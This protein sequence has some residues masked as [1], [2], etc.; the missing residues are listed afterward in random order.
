MLA[1]H[2]TVF[3]TVLYKDYLYLPWMHLQAFK[4]F[5][6]STSGLEQEKKI[7]L[8]LNLMK[9]WLHW[10]KHKICIELAVSFS[11]LAS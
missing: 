10:V 11:H 5:L 2:T 4:L 7:I 6:Q 3:E 9:F 1:T 8:T